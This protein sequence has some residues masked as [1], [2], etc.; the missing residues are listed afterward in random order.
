M[1]QRQDALVA[2]ARFVDVA[3]TTARSIAGRQVATV[4][5]I[6]AFPG[7]RNVI[8]GRVSL[9]LEIRELD[10]AKLDSVFEQ[11]RGESVKIG[12]ATSTSFAFENAY[13]STPHSWMSAYA[14]DP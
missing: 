7:A 12:Q 9:S 10:A 4:G 3:H 13:A 5:R 1:D 2:A 11:I 14:E 8:P 6:Q